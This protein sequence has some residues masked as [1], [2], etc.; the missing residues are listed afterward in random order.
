MIEFQEFP[1]IFRLSREMIVTEKLDGT[2]AQVYVTDDGQV[3]AIIS[4]VARMNPA[5]RALTKPFWS[6]STTITPGK[7]CAIAFVLS[8]LALLTTITSVSYF[9]LA[10][11][12]AIA[13]R[14]P[15]K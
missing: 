2:N 4:P 6:S 8:V 9:V 1:K 3:L 13:L 10:V 14:Q 12:A 7:R 5:W 15:P 11:S